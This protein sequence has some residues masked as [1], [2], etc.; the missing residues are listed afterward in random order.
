MTIAHRLHTII[1]SD[2]VL[3][4]DAGRVAEFDSP[5]ALLA[6]PGSAFRAMVEE[7]ARGGVATLQ[8]LV[9]AAGGQQKTSEQ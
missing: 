8:Q 5:S 2:R 1:D 4:L 9:A 3:L 6:T 7:T